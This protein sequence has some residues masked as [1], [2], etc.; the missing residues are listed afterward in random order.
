MLF[1][2][3]TVDLSRVERRTSAWIVYRLISKLDADGVIYSS[4][5]AQCFLCVPRGRGNAISEWHCQTVTYRARQAN[6]I[7]GLLYRL[8]YSSLSI[9]SYKCPFF[10]FFSPWFPWFCSLPPRR[11]WSVRVVRP[12]DVVDPLHRR[13]LADIRFSV[14]VKRGRQLPANDSISNRWYFTAPCI[15][16]LLHRRH[17]L[18]PGD[19]LQFQQLAPGRGSVACRRCRLIVTYC[20]RQ[21]SAY[22]FVTS[23]SGID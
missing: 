23:L 19:R 8:S 10:F 9:T 2:N 15:S 4:T 3:S 6:S 5:N 16:A 1:R 11:G 20:R 18:D 14:V 13:M 7:S 12:V 22:T 21:S 17:L